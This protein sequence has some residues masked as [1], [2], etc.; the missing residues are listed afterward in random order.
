[1]R[2]LLTGCSGFIG[3][4]VLGAL[5]AGGHQVVCAARHPG[6]SADPQLRF[7]RADFSKDTDKSAWLA[8]LSGIDAVINTVGI[9]RQ[10][11]HQSFAA[12]HTDTPRALFAACAEVPGVR[13][14][15]QLSALGADRGAA[16][17]YHLSKKAADDFLAGLPLHACILQP[18]LVYGKGGAS[19][20]VFK[21]LASMPFAVRFGSAAQLVQPV[22][23][24]DVAA[25][26]AALVS[27]PPEGPPRRIALVGPAPMGFTDY[28]AALRAA[29]GMGKL[30]VLRLPDWAAR[31][32]AKLGRFLPGALLDDDALSMLNRD[33]TADP[34]DIT[35]LLGRAPRPVRDFILD[36]AAER[37][38]AKLGWLLPVL[39][40]SIAAV[41]IFTALTSAL[42]YPV[43]DSF[44]LLA[45]TGV[46]AS[47]RPLM[48]YGAA[49]FDLALGVGIL[50]LARR[51][52]LWLMQLL[53]IAF[54]T[55]VIAW[56]LPEFLLHPYGPLT[57]N[58][59]M[60]AAIW[61]LYELEERL[62]T[63]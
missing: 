30:R 6:N 28:L 32:M 40:W 31:A 8:R 9:F 17:A 63:T 57:K 62:W 16:S 23:I 46:P 27:N 42:L 3:Q 53:L 39:R 51:R 54:Y 38:Q 50:V 34:A 56:K 20:R 41:W 22:H 24:E 18:S 55:V 10:T 2:V 14:V 29:M 48:L 15:I 21:T 60:L 25:A 7:I 52:W 47:L 26:V 5:L 58:L 35:Q 49:G 13:L 61:L 12:L 19:A 4:H 33:N 43:Q 37:A 11:A 36:P 59:P 44:E 1:M 45:R